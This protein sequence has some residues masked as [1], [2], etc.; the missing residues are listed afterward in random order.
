VDDG[1]GQQK[2]ECVSLV[3][4]MCPQL[5]GKRARDWRMGKPVKGATLLPG[6]AIAS[7]NPITKT[8]WHAAIYVR[9]DGNGI[10]VWDQ[11]CRG[12]TAHAPKL[13]QLGWANA[14][15]PHVAGDN[16]RVIE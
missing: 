2:G 13:N 5:R 16:F 1:S 12:S 6:T 4:L 3:K 15:H 10:W 9:Q 11:Y 7:F 8:Y 14:G